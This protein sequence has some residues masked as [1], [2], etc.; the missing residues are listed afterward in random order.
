MAAAFLVEFLVDNR[1]HN[2]RGIVI[3]FSNYQMSQGPVKVVCLTSAKWI[4][5][6]FTTTPEY[7]G[8]ADAR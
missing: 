6:Q 4:V 3:V 5:D 8:N 1:F 7:F 2:S